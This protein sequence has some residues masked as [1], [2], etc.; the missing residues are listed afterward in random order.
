MRSIDPPEQFESFCLGFDVALYRDNPL[1]RKG[2][3]DS[4]VDGAIAY[5]LDGWD[6]RDLTILQAFLTRILESPDSAATMNDMW[7]KTRPRYAFFSGPDAPADKPAII[8][9]FTRVLKAIEKKLS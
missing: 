4:F 2:D 7:K 1:N 3:F 6:Q 8:Q 5:G 9:I